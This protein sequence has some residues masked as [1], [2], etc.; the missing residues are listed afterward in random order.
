VDG[1]APA[2]IF[3]RPNWLPLALLL[4]DA[5]L[6]A[7]SVVLAYQ[8]RFHFDRIPQ[9]HAEHPAFA[10]YLAAI[11]VVVV[12]FL[13]ALGVNHQYRSWRG[14]T[15]LDQLFAMVSGLALGGM[16][17]LAA[18]SVYR[19]FEYSRLT[20][21]YTVIIS[22]LL[23]TAERYLL[24]QYETR[25]RRR[26][27]GTERVLV[28]GTGT[29]SQLLI[30]RMTMFPQYGY[31]VTG[32]V[33]DRLEPGTSFAGAPV[34]GR[35]ERLPSLIRELR[36]DQVFLALP[37][38]SRDQ[39]VG[40]VKLCEDEQVEF[41]IVPDLL[42]VMSSRVA[43]DAIDGLPLVG[44][45]RSNLRGAAALA[46]RAIDMAVSLLGLILASWLMLLIAVLIRLTSRGPILFRQ[47]RVGK[48]GRIFILYKFRSMVVNAEEETGPI[49]ATRDDRRRTALGRV[50]RRLS[51]DEL[52]Q[53]FNILRGD[54]S[55][56]G[57]R[58]ER[59]YFVERF[60]EQTP[61]YLERQQV[62]PGVTGWAQVNDLRGDTSIADRTIYDIYYI[63]NWSLK[64]DLK[65]MV[66]TLFRLLFQRQ[67][68]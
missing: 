13:M 30:Q 17:L 34:V 21:A 28:V 24:R 8:Y 38:A 54:M 20:L 25:L 29:S 46:K 35:V 64:L 67:A 18:M 4:G 1:P 36:A 59:P 45:R 6:T 14:R 62:R 15:L 10:P 53:L 41:K 33:D 22:G 57:P 66:L 50:L 48:G 2:L 63:E 51:L 26:G 56:V 55:L 65:I 61:R 49:F 5:I 60:R 32:V 39:L 68:Y 11:P 40:L 37:G 42:E 19:G 47:E 12:L 31:H 3:R 16:L 9:V 52:P 23:L 44:I 27:I 43:A 7:A 58:P